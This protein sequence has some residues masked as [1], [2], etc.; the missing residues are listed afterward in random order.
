[1]SDPITI[2]LISGGFLFLNRV[3]AYF[4]SRKTNQK[5]DAVKKEVT[6]MNA[7]SMA[8]LADKAETRRIDRVPLSERT[9][10]D[11]GH[12]ESAAGQGVIDSNQP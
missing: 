11:L 1:M 2:A 8:V 9:A 10:A 6:T 5:V 7:Q 12:L 3:L 4:E